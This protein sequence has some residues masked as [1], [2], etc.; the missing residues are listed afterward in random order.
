MALRTRPFSTDLARY[1]LFCY[2]IQ[3]VVRCCGG[4]A[5]HVSG[6]ASIVVAYNGESGAFA[7]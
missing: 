6:K 4:T 5:S 2:T 7:A 1:D 3:A